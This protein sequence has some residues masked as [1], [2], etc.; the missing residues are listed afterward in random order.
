MTL[1]EK[2]RIILLWDNDFEIEEPSHTTKVL[3]R[4]WSGNPFES[5][6]FDNREQAIDMTYDD[7]QRFIQKMCETIERERNYY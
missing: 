6:V 5:L 4:T 3:A 7:V 2:L 1:E